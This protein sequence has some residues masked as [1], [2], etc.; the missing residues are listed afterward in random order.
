MPEEPA[1]EKP[2]PEE[3]PASSA[4]SMEEATLEELADISRH[5]DSLDDILDYAYEQRST[6][7][8][9][10]AILANRKALERYAEDD[11]APFIAIDLGNI[12]KEQADYDAALRVYEKALDIP[13][14]AQSDVAYQE[15]ANNL[16]YLRTIQYILS[17][18]NALDLPFQDIPKEYLE[19][20]EADFQSRHMNSRF[21][22]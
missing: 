17:K 8:L 10:L 19:E 11:Y 13:A 16:S 22:G 2:V 21:I 7:N 1:A 4:E 6:G 18:H 3:R 14:I 20:I 9:R 15:F 12:Y 5:L